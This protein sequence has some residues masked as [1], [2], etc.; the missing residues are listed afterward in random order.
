MNIIQ[1]CAKWVQVKKS[2]D[3]NTQEK[4]F[5]TIYFQSWK[6]T[7]GVSAQTLKHPFNVKFL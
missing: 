6:M 7:F 1:K 5:V 4:Y 2:N 3:K